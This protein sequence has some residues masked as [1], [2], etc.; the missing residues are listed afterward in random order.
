MSLIDE[1]LFPQAAVMLHD[2]VE[3]SDERKAEIKATFI[4][5]LVRFLGIYAE[6][7]IGEGIQIDITKVALHVNSARFENDDLYCIE[8]IDDVYRLLEQLTIAGLPIWRF[9]RLTDYQKRIFESGYSELLVSAKM[10]AAAERPCYGCIWF[11]EF[12]TPFGVLRKCRKPETEFE[13]YRRG[14]I[15]PDV[16]TE[17]KWCTTLDKIPDEVEALDKFYKSKFINS[18]ESARNNFRRKLNED[19]FRIP[20][21]LSDKE[22]VDLDTCYDPILDLACAFNNLKTK[23]TRQTEIRRAMYIEGM[24]RFFEIYAQCEVG[25]GYIAD[26]KNIALYV[27]ELDSSEIKFIKSYEDVYD[28]LEEKIINGFNVKKFIKYDDEY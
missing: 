18:L 4:E 6:T 10:K 26:I 12:E 9:L 2:G 5:G 15:D 19:P 1:N 7:E 14:S 17:C 21:E 3:I 8:S 11:D 24:I 13:I 28:D 23:S 20:K 22:K 25:N 16:I 27:D